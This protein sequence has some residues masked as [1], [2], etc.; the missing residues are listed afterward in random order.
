[1]A[2][3]RISEILPAKGVDYVG[4]LPQKFQD[5]VKFAT[6]ISATSKS[7]DAAQTA[8]KFITGPAVAP[9]F[10]AKGIEPYMRSL[11]Q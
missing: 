2:T 4:P 7:M 11:A 8:V 10:K 9:A 6:G 3:T 1:M 5:Y